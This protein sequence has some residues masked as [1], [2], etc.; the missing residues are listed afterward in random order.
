MAG[1]GRI[2]DLVAKLNAMASTAWQESLSRQLAEQALQLID[3]GFK[4]ERDPYSKRW[5]PTRQPHQILQLSGDLRRSFG[6][7]RLAA[8]GFEVRSDIVYGV[9]QQP[10][11]NMVPTTALGLPEKWQREFDRVAIRFVKE[12]M[13]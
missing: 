3:D 4:N 10:K 13:R 9:Y 6:I 2:A 8:D 7:A 12:T 11:R 1:T 5:A